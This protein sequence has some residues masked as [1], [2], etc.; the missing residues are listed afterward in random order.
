MAKLRMHN[1]KQQNQN[2][3]FKAPGIKLKKIIV[4]SQEVGKNVQGDSHASLT[5]F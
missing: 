4:N 2:L 5:Q 3:N 1:S